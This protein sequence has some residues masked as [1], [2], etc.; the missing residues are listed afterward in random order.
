[1]DEARHSMIANLPSPPKTMPRAKGGYR[2]SY[3]KRKCLC[4]VFS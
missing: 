3:S 1:M 2:K 4:L